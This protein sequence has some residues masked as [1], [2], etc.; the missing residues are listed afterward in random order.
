ML[1]EAAHQSR[2]TRTEAIA[3]GTVC[4]RRRRVQVQGA[5][6]REII[7]A[8][9]APGVSRKTPSRSCLSFDGLGTLAR[10]RNRLWAEFP[11]LF[12]PLVNASARLSTCSLSVVVQ[13]A[14]CLVCL[15]LFLGCAVYGQTQ[16]LEE[17]PKATRDRLIGSYW[18]PTKGTP[19]FNS[20]AG[21][22]VCRGCHAEE[23]SSQINTPMAKAAFQIGE[24]TQSPIV[25]AGRLQS[26]SY[27]YR[28]SSDNLGFRL[29]ATSGKQT[30]VGDVRWIFGAGVHGQT[31]ILENKNSLYESQVSTFGGLHGMDLTPGHSPIEAGDIKN[32]LGERLSE[33]TAR[34]CFGCHTTRS[35]TNSRFDVTRAI[36]G[37]HCEACHGPGLG[38]VKAIKAGEV[39]EGLKEIMNPV[40]LTPVDSVDFCGACHRTGMDV[41][42]AEGAYGPVN[43][44]FQP[45]RLE[46]SRCWGTTGDDRLT[47][48]ACH[49]PHK[50]LV[51]N[52]SSYDARCLGCHSPQPAESHGANQ[53]RTI[54]PK[55][56]ANCT[57][58]HMPKYDVPG[59]HAKFTDHF[60]RVVRAGE[61]YP[62]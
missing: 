19:T 53:I 31:Y 54:C 25:P 59:M 28:I 7:A 33:T 55:A 58:C 6:I 40:H 44:R 27:L 36:P 15:L 38:H 20:Y 9:V 11:R 18:W 3:A 2:R 24:K 5:G 50:P 4:K 32:A 29:T 61:S 37:V 14:A 48:I 35:S 45:Y 42:E 52:D 1:V 10:S 60:I 23:A 56:T 8:S 12:L 51:Q 46:K 62:N 57:S 47:C 41:V 34:L 39:D 13:I 49:N 22:N 21:E 16:T 26:G 30:V 17:R 43:V